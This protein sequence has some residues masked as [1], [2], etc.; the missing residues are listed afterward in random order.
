MSANGNSQQAGQITPAQARM[1]ALYMEVS[2]AVDQLLRP[3]RRQRPQRQPL[4][5][6]QAMMLLSLLF[7][8]WLPFAWFGFRPR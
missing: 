1:L 5:V 6:G 7:L 2:D 4:Q 8:A 3:V